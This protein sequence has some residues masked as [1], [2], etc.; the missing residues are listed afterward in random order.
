MLAPIY[1]IAYLRKDIFTMKVIR[2]WKRLL[3]QSTYFEV[4]KTQLDKVL[5]NLMELGLLSAEGWNSLPL[6]VSSKTNFSL[7]SSP[8][9]KSFEAS[10]SCLKSQPLRN[11][12]NPKLVI[13][14][15]GEWDESGTDIILSGS[16][17]VHAY[18]AAILFCKG[19]LSIL[20]CLGSFFIMA[21]SLCSLDQWLKECC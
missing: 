2:H 8:Y 1:T 20:V 11:R 12:R 19:I 17:P 14:V 15:L 18:S 21:M 5:I 16:W 9:A 10:T 4:L 13:P 7:I 3:A 6:E